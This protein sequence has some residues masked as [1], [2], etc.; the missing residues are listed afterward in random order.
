MWLHKFLPGLTSC[1]PVSEALNFI[2]RPEDSGVCYFWN[3]LSGVSQASVLWTRVETNILVGLRQITGSSKTQQE[4]REKT[5][6]IAG[7]MIPS[8]KVD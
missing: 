8:K 7:L 6:A 2:S 4:V 3:V 5:A 1:R